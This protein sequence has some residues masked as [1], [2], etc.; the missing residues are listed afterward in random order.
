[1][2]YPAQEKIEYPYC[3]VLNVG[4]PPHCISVKTKIFNFPK[5]RP[6]I[7]SGKLFFSV[8]SVR[9]ILNRDKH[10]TRADLSSLEKHLK[11]IRDRENVHPLMGGS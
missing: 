8:P 5:N 10:L 1:M 7:G 2:I 9:E 4:L 6:K 11:R 3:P